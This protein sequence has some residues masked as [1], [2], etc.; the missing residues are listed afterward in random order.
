M[1]FGEESLRSWWNPND[2]LEV[3]GETLFTND[4]AHNDDLKMIL[5]QIPK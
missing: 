4:M 2:Y 5:N 3:D 1:E